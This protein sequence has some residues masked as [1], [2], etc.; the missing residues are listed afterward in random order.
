LSGT[1]PPSQHGYRSSRL[2]PVPGTVV[3]PPTGQSSTSRR[4]A[5]A[6][7]DAL[8]LPL[9][10]ALP[11]R[12]V[13]LEGQRIAL[14]YEFRRWAWR[15]ERCAEIALGARAVAQRE[16]D[17]VL[18]VGNVMP[19]AGVRG[20]IV[21]DKYEAFPGVVNED[22]LDFAPGRRYGLVLSLSTL[23]HVGW[24][25]E[26]RDPGKA[27]AALEAMSSLVADDGALL[28]TI[29]VGVHRCL[30]EAFTADDGPFDS[31]ALLVKTSRL[32]RWETRHPEGLDRFRYGEPYA[33]G[34]AVLVGTRGNPLG[35]EHVA[36]T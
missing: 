29:P 15:T 20:H 8:S 18:E 27:P 2:R 17:E 31:I 23:E 13:E 7:L 1:Q 6:A 3:L 25:E 10:A 4:L 21:V 5:N 12:H 34:N 32:A 19:L 14:H 36:S 33:C 24:D 26:P 16:P 11:H 22:I 28:I 9:V 35:T 30:E